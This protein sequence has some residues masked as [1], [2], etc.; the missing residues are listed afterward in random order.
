MINLPNGLVKFQEDCVSYL[1]DETSK[2]HRENIIV[3]SPTG[4]GKTIMLIAYIDRFIEF[5]HENIAFI[6]LTPGDG[7][8]EEQSKEKMK[9]FAP[10][11]KSLDIHDALTNGFEVESTSFINW[12][13]VTNKNNKAITEN[14]RKNLYDRIAEAHRKGIEFI[15]VIDEE[16]RHDT[17]KSNDIINSFSPKNI[18][19]VSATAR[20]NSADKWYE[21]PEIDVINS[22][23]ITKAM[24]INE[25]IDVGEG[26]S[27]FNESQLLIDK[28]NTKRKEI[29]EEYTSLEKNIRPLVVIQFPNNSEEYIDIVENQ[30]SELGYTY[31]NG[32]VAKWMAEEKNKINLSNITDNNSHVSFLLIKQAIS[33][34][35]DC[36]R[37]KILIKLRERMNEDFEIQTLGRIRRMPEIKHYEN[38]LLD[39]CYL[40]TF[41]E[42]YKEVVKEGIENSYETTR[43]YLKNI[44]KDFRITKELR[45]KDYDGI[46]LRDIYK[47]IYNF[48]IN[49]YKLTQS[50]KRNREI[51][52]TNGFIIG[53]QVY[54][55]YMQGRFITFKDVTKSEEYKGISYTVN[56]HDHGLSLL[57]SIDNVKR[58]VSMTSEN[59]RAVF[60][61]LYASTPGNKDKILSLN[62]HEW[63]AFIINNVDK[64]KEDFREVAAS[65]EYQVSFKELN[66]KTEMFKL[67]LEDKYKYDPNESLKE[68]FEKFTYDK[69][70]TQM[71]VSG[72]RSVSE[73]LFEQY[74]ESNDNIEWFYKNG[75]TGQQY[76]SVV[77]VQG[78]DK[79]F[80]FYP[81][82]IIKKTNGDIW[83]IETK[84]GEYKG[85]SKNIDDMVEHKFNAFRNYARKYGVNWGFVR[86]KDNRLY[87]NNTE[88]VDDLSEENWERLSDYL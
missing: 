26:E 42:K 11:L 36:P 70:T 38:E 69:Y 71:T 72:L 4:S 34:G 31:D 43:L 3:K 23:L 62:I 25:D 67:P 39:C 37:A 35:W 44:A 82:Y 84:G 66:P 21:I 79:Q 29:I 86:D 74:C 8:L 7:E 27:L 24:Y 59:V 41:D 47:N 57:H 6:W 22:G 16:H 15:V 61:R 75:D 18:I 30:L 28:A 19:R 20:E 65:T 14:E 85:Q 83:I 51:L 58:A 13:M 68:H 56:T 63:Y 48:L 46:G 33:T 32:M 10:H 12:Q 54:G 1:L 9:K 53:N 73:Q 52:E 55:R 5:V 78:M 40:Y 64:L 76:L 88:Y 81:D 50:K 17:V 45:D 60:K 77:Y 49:K 2:N 80:L 87:I